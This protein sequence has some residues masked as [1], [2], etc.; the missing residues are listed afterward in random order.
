MNIYIIFEHCHEHFLYV[1]MNIFL[2]VIVNIIQGGKVELDRMMVCPLY[3]YSLNSLKCYY[4]IN[5]LFDVPNSIQV[6]NNNF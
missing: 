1:V 4:F 6:L 5:N 3:F 2:Y